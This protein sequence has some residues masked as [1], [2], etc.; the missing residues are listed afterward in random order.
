MG[1]G[2]GIHRVIYTYTLTS[3][4]PVGTY[5]FLTVTKAPQICSLA[6]INRVQEAS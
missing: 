6:R 2:V 4:Y 1:S 3:D 5:C